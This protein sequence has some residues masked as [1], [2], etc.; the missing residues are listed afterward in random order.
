MNEFFVRIPIREGDLLGLERAR[1]ERAASNR[2]RTAR[3][4]SASC[5][6]SGLRLPHPS[7][8]LVNTELLVNATVEPDADGDG[9]GDD[10]Q[11]NCPTN[12]ATQ[13]ACSGR[14]WAPS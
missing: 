11:D 1:R 12:A 13:G 3:S 4:S 5:R 14:W 8:T 6:R 2:L 10:S 7:E 9:F